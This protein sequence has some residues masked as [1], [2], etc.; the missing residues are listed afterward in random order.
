MFALL[1]LR[2]TENDKSLI[3]SK[4]SIACGQ[5]KNARVKMLNTFMISHNFVVAHRNYILMFLQTSP[6]KSFQCICQKKQIEFHF[7]P[8]CN[9]FKILKIIDFRN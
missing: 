3:K 9:K 2:M 4:K 7:M 5:N 1:R 8:K 6:I